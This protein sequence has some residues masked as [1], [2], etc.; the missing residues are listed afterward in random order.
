MTEHELLGSAAAERHRE[1]GNECVAAEVPAVL[2]HP[3]L[4]DAER[5]AVR[6][7]G[8]L[9]DRVGPGRQECD[10][11][12]TALVVRND[13]PLLRV[14]QCR[15]TGPEEDL[16]E[17]LLELGRTHGLASPPCREQRCLVGEV[18]QIGAR[19]AC[20]LL[21]DIGQVHVGC[22]WDVPRVDAQDRLASGTVRVADGH[23]AV[24]PARPQQGRIQDVGSVRCGD[25]DHRGRR[26]KAVHL[27]QQLVQRLLALVVAPAQARPTLAPDRVD[28]VDEDDRRRGRLRLREQI[29][30]ARG[31]DTDEQLDELGRSDAEEGDMRLA[32]HRP[33]EERLP[34]SR[35]A[36]EEHA[37]WQPGAELLEA[38]GV[39][40]EVHDLGQLGL[41]LVLARDIGERDA[42]PFLV[43]EAR[44][45]T[46]DP[47]DALLAALRLA[48]RVEENAHEKQHRQQAPEQPEDRAEEG[49][50]RAR[51]G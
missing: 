8:D 49:A 6:H 14:R 38:G 48:A 35:R 43:V 11:R 18:R 28:L 7:D 9:L 32:R 4:R 27:G 46:A 5:S 2:F 44:G 26:V 34:G 45:R 39:H 36:D 50:R 1:P 42:G 16:V 47:E 3:L 51:V 17:T 23:L 21:R 20:C 30:H 24:E 33:R 22:Q 31:A 10:E 25:D 40:E 41:G 19:K 13:S 12:M 15:L 29:A 37:T